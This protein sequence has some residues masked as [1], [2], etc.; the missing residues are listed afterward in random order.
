MRLLI[1]GLAALFCL[2]SGI[3]LTSF[4]RRPEYGAK[5]PT[6]EG[7]QAEVG[8]RRG[9]VGMVLNAFEWAAR[10]VVHYPQYIWL[11]A[12]IDRMD[13]YFW[14]YAGVNALYLAMSLAQIFLRL[15]RFDRVQE[16]A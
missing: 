11:L 13:I 6:E 10:F 15:G 7:Q 3:A 12:L 2:A 9:P 4:M 14:G 5:P 1:V 16:A 8:K